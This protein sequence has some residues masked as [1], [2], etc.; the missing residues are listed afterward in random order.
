MSGSPEV[1]KEFMAKILELAKVHKDHLVLI[2]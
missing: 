1:V 2:P